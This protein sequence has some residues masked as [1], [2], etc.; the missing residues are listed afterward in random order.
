MIA[1]NPEGESESESGRISGWTIVQDPEEFT[2][3]ENES[4]TEPEENQ[5]LDFWVVYAMAT[6]EGVI[7]FNNHGAV[8]FQRKDDPRGEL[9]PLK[10]EV[11]RNLNVFFFEWVDENGNTFVVHEEYSNQFLREY[12]EALAAQGV[13]IYADED[14]YYEYELDDGFYNEYEEEDY[15][16]FYQESDGYYYLY[17]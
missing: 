3:P 10:M 1:Q 7:Y 5:E 4:E 12:A 6:E 2:D 15:S 8:F 11:L 13:R 17:M 9:L 14:E 16:W